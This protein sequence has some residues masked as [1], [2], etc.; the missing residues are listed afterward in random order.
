[1]T[2]TPRRPVTKTIGS[3][4]FDDPYDWLQHDS[5]EA[6]AWQWE[7]DAIAQREAEAWPHF[8]ALKEQLRVCD[9]AN[10]LALPSPP[11]SRGG[12]WFW[13]APTPGGGGRVL[14]TADTL[15]EPGRQIFTMADA[16]GAE[17][18]AGGAV[19]WWEVSSDGRRV[20]ALICL[21]GDMM[22]QWHVFDVDSGASVCDPLPAIGY[23]G[24]IPGW[25]PDGSGF[26][27]HGRDADG[28]HRIQF[29]ALDDGVADR[30]EAVFDN[31]E[32]PVQMSGLT[33]TVSP[34]GRWVIADSGPHERTAYMICDTR[35]GEWRP[36]I[37]EG[38]HGEL[39]GGW[40]DA[41]T[42]VARAHGDDTP[43]GRIV[44]IPAATSRDRD[45]WR[46]IV[47][48]GQA[49]IRAA[50][51][52][53]GKIAVAELLHVS[54]RIRLID[55]F[56]GSE[57]VAPL[58]E[59]GA[60]WISGW[61]RFE[62][63]DALAFDYA[64]FTE[65]G[66]IYLFDPDS[67]ALSTLTPPLAELD[68]ITVTQHFA[69]SQDGVRV[70]YFMVHRA[71]LD[72]GVPQPALVAAY[73][74]FNSAYTPAY[75]GHLT[76]FVRA[77]GVLIH[78]NIRGG[79]EYGK[80]WHDSGRL[81]CKWNSYLDLFAVTEDAIARGVTAPEKL[82]MTGASNGGLLAGV[83]IVHRPDLF[84]VVVPEVPIFDMMQP[85]P[86][87]PALEPIRAIFRQDYGDAGD[88]VMSKII[89]SYSPYHQIRD[90]VAYPAVYQVF[91]EKDAGCM[92]FHGRKF[93]ARL[94]A[95]SSSGHRTLLRVWRDTGHASFDADISVRQRAEWLGFV[96][97]ELGMVPVSS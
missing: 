10:L 93:T 37:P 67:G 51:V 62:R 68:G 20:A 61:H 49:V 29:L 95:A 36:F 91:G 80:I 57:Q 11:R 32:V 88:A 40:L 25:L 17:D 97:A 58:K 74:G 56:D 27:L 8:E 14:W 2:N 83:C 9:V 82:A 64:G 7:Q 24:A 87:D 86:D 94:D 96:M 90:G 89:Y 18:A 13:V 73:G 48:E 76:P 21:H 34:G 46:E 28:R 66:G 3:V 55:P 16:V 70:P 39:T 69:T 53:G 38:Y 12:R 1:M 35:T 85:L 6:L 81:A 52:F 50:G 92:P 5:E 44:A 4:T 43:R 65:T 22:G 75:L 47:P 26:Y 78:A 72:L 63:S 77:G 15:G 45:T 79:G 33:C 19:L 84:R 59:P 42:Y 41:D 71:D 54:L 31:A 60:S 23:S 30:P